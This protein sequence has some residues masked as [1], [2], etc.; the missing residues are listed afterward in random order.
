VGERSERGRI[1]VAAAQEETSK[2][3]RKWKKADA[4]ELCRLYNKRCRK[5]RNISK[6]GDFIVE[7]DGQISS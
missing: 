7:E 1:R 2:N 5:E 3:V 6:S 4:R